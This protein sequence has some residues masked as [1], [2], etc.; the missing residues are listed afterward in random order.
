MALTPEQVEGLARVRR[1][2]DALASSNDSL[3]EWVKLD[4]PTMA[5]VAV[6]GALTD[7]HLALI[8]LV[9]VVEAV[10]ADGHA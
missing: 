6:S 1:S 10:I 7:L 2:I 9:A 8:D 5:F 3:L 4:R